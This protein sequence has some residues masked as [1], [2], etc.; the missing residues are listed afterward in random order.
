MRREITAVAG[1]LWRDG[2]FLAVER[3]EGK[4][5]AGYWEFPGGKIEAGETAMDALYRELAEE[6]G[7]TVRSAFPWRVITH[8]YGHGAVT[9]HV[10]H[11]AAYS[12]E[13][14]P[15]EGQ[16]MCWTKPARAK[17]HNFLPADL[18]LVEELARTGQPLF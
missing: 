14:T 7:V 1:I 12:G 10:F 8:E 11:V 5:M 9:L 17:T 3:P 18:P 4:I 16:K 2:E 13:P 15:L 6:L